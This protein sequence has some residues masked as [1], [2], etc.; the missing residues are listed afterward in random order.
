MIDYE[1]AWNT[2]GVP[3]GQVNQ[4]KALTAEQWLNPITNGWSAAYVQAVERHEFAERPLDGTYQLEL[5]VAPEVQ[6]GQIDRV[7]V[8]A[9]TSYWV[10]QN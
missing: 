8:L 10:R 4:A 9:D 3:V 1:G 2:L 5:D 6:L 7:Q